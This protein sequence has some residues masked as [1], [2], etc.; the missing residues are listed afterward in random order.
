MPRTDHLALKEKPP[1]PR[2]GDQTGAA[3]L[4]ALTDL[5]E[6]DVSLVNGFSNHAP[7]VVE[8]LFNLGRAGAIKAWMAD[9][10]STRRPRT[11][12]S[13]P[14]VS[15]RLGDY[16]HF[17]LFRRSISRDLADRPWRDVLSEHAAHLAPGY[18]GAALHGA[19]RVGHA[20]RGL[21]RLDHPATRAELASA[22]A[23]WSVAYAAPSAAFGSV[24][25]PARLPVEAAWRALNPVPSDRRRNDGLIVRA[26]QQVRHAEDFEAIIDAVDWPE[27]PVEATRRV[28]GLFLELFLASARTGLTALVM[29]H[30]LTGLAASWTIGRETDPDLHG[31]LVREAFRAGASLHVAY[32]P[33]DEKPSLA[34]GRAS[35]TADAL[36][37]AAV[38]SGDDHVIKLTDACLFFEALLGEPR[39]RAAATLGQ[40]LMD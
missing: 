16:A 5:Q 40:A 1:T 32:S 13:A 20:V 23:Y 28:A 24:P 34:E 2:Q 15:P 18:A 3:Y 4:D 38:R 9:T 31:R 11:S 22:L 37:E 12:A 17:G 36:V 39:F 7:M 8:A 6:T 10:A 27:D 21:A 19:I 30:A 33:F 25:S 29:T 35:L 26:L 14:G